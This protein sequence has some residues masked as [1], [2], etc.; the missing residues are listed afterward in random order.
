MWVA[1]DISPIVEGSETQKRT[2]V[3]ILAHVTFQIAV[4]SN[5]AGGWMLEKSKELK[6]F[7]RK[8]QKI[9]TPDPVWPFL[10]SREPVGVE[11]DP[12][13]RFGFCLFCISLDHVNSSSPLSLDFTCPA[14]WKKKL[15][16]M[17]HFSNFSSLWESSN[18]ETESEVTAFP[19]EGCYI[20]WLC[21][22]RLRA[23]ACIPA[24]EGED[25]LGSRQPLYNH[26]SFYGS[27][28]IIPISPPVLRIVIT[29]FQ[30]LLESPPGCTLW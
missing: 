4:A 29:L 10:N 3:P 23:A 9:N 6:S 7:R 28:R 13:S 14:F 8:T 21:C 5:S 30:D 18:T 2:F 25:G 24:D 20:P 19:R 12:E 11:E 17:Y 15:V 1:C 27:V 22:P 26:S 16:L